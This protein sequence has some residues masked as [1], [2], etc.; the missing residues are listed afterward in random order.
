MS[1]SHKRGASRRAAPVPV[2]G[3]ADPVPKRRRRASDFP[4]S[5]SA[6]TEERS[7]GAFLSA[8][9]SRL[10]PALLVP[11]ALVAFALLV[12]DSPLVAQESRTG[13]ASPAVVSNPAAVP[14][15]VA[16]TLLLLALQAFLSASEIALITLRKSRLRQ[17][18]EESRPAALRI[19][20]LLA[21]P[22]RLTATIHTGVTLT[23]LLAAA[24]SAIVITPPV[25]A[26][27]RAAHFPFAGHYALL[28]A[29]VLV[30][31]P[32]AVLTLIGGAIAPRSLAVRYPEAL[33]LFASGPIS[34]LEKLLAPLVGSVT[35]LSNILLRPLGGTASFLTPTVNE[36]E[37]KMLVEASEEQ[38][39][40]EAGET[41][42]IHSVLNFAD[43]VAR[44]VMTPRIDMTGASVDSSLADLVTQINES[45]HSRIPV[46][47][48]DLDN[49]V[50][51]VHA[52]DL[53]MRIVAPRDAIALRDVMRPPY[54]IPENKKIDELLTEFRRSKQQMA[55]VRDEYGTVAGIVT[56]EDV[57]EEIVGDI[58]DEYDV[59]EPTIHV[60]D[61]ANTL[62]DGRISLDDVNERMA[63][64][65]PTDEA[66]T[67]GG[68]VFGLL[69]HQAQAGE[70]IT[71][72]EVEFTVE[73]TGGRRITRVRLTRRPPDENDENAPPSR[74]EANSITVSAA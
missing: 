20:A 66:D 28:L 25:A 54:F 8:A 21:N 16:F 46:Y 50:G 67:I 47:D 11:G 48:G 3:S 53:L 17:L 56:L 40:L 7:V 52:K 68:F 15:A 72:G 24:L 60:L 38:G 37:F 14:L 13:A 42:M 58:Q 57:V 70:R 43:T 36:E 29:L 4:H 23:S 49:I 27:L 62:F 30:L 41:E 35:L 10:L 69:G 61:A 18:V 26:G 1:S 22:A 71:W 51:I 45:G 59:D 44:K 2:S 63:L 32:V 65:L 39:V 6:K 19:E 33:A 9:L 31:L 12:F 73:T 55:I 64:Q 34:L 74:N 5:P